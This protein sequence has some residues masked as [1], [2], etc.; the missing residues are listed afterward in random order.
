MDLVSKEYLLKLFFAIGGNHKPDESKII[1][2]K[3]K[4]YDALYEGDAQINDLLRI[5]HVEEIER[6]YNSFW[7]ARDILAPTLKRLANETDLDE[8]DVRILAVSIGHIDNFENIQPRFEKKFLNGLEKH[9]S[10]K[11]E[12]DTIKMAFNYNI[13]CRLLRAKFLERENVL[14]STKKLQD[15]FDAYIEILLDI[16]NKDKEKFLLFETVTLIRK[17]AFYNDHALIEKGFEML[18]YNKENETY[19]IMRCECVDYQIHV[20]INSTKASL[21]T[22][23]GKNIKKERTTRKMTQEKLATILGVEAATVSNTERGTKTIFAVDLIII[24]RIFGISLDVL[25]GFELADCQNSEDLKLQQL[26]HIFNRLTASE[27][28]H[29]IQ[30]AESILELNEHR[31]N[32]PLEIS[33]SDDAK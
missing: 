21:N 18:E 29:L 33:R 1:E 20:D 32:T 12:Y 6:H 13:S 7:E 28:D 17:G 3:L 24:A 25:T 31:K 9:Y 4:G 10:G 30:I 15:M 14:E 5:S 26:I 11:P 8:W 2:N 22:A 23:I 19:K 16:F 27:Q